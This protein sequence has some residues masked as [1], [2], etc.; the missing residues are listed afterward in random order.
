MTL[1]PVRIPVLTMSGF[2]SLK[3]SVTSRVA[4]VWNER[5]NPP[6]TSSRF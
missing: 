4:R 6:R 2:P 1:V 5:P 3:A